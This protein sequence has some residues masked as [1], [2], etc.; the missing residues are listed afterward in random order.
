[1][2]KPISLTIAAAMACAMAVPVLAADAGPQ[3]RVDAG[4]V[5]VSQGAE[6][7]A[8]EQS[9]MEVK[10]GDRFMLTEG[11]LATIVYA[12]DCQRKFTRPGVY[13][14]ESECRKAA[15]VGMAKP[16]IVAIG[17]AAIAAAAGGG[18]GG[19][20]DSPPGPQ[21]PPVSR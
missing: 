10:A 1:M 4:K 15:P 11:A 9:P 8:I 17:V 20:G 18:G 2:M 12:G 19:D 3:L 6:F 14:V 16:A 7:G 21:V 13:S 5:L